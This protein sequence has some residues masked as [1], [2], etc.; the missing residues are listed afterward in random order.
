MARN[1]SNVRIAGKAGLFDIRTITDAKKGANMK[2]TKE[3]LE[4]QGA[5]QD[6]KQWFVAQRATKIE[7]VIKKLT[8]GKHFGWANWTITRS[9]TQE[10]NVRYACFSASLSLRAFEKIF[11]NDKRP[12]LAIEAALKWANFPTEENKTAAQ[13]ARSAAWSALGS[14]KSAA[15]K[16]ILLFGLELLLGKVLGGVFS[17]WK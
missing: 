5:C 6:G 14:A 4:K 16:K 15:W 3:W 11:P 13:S 10:Q 9:M 12:R 8:K 2:I 17:K 7:S 1:G